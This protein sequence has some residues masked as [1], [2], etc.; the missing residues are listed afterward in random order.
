MITGLR[1]S[2]RLITYSKKAA[3]LLVMFNEGRAAAFSGGKVTQFQQYTDTYQLAQA[4][5]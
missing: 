4:A 1:K 5:K 2:E 3:T